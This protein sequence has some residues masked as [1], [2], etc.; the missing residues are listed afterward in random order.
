M[1][2]CAPPMV[3]R[4]VFS[5]PARY[6]DAGAGLQVVR[7]RGQAERTRLCG[8]E[9]GVAEDAG[10]RHALVAQR[11]R[12]D[13]D[14]ET[15]RLAQPAEADSCRALGPDGAGTSCGSERERFGR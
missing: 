11:R 2:T 9:G 8:V 13:G 5:P 10:D 1:L 3:S 4:G 6:A 7:A 14:R 12:V 15:R